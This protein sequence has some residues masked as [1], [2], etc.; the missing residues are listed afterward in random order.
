MW[1]ALA[2]AVDWDNVNNWVFGTWEQILIC[3][4]GFG[5]IQNQLS[6]T[7]C[8]ISSSDLVIRNLCF[9]RICCSFL[10]FFNLDFFF[11]FLKMILKHIWF[12]SCRMV[13]VFHFHSS[14]TEWTLLL[15]Q[16]LT[17]EINHP[18]AGAFPSDMGCDLV[19]CSKH[20]RNSD[21]GY[22]KS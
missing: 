1:M 3:A 15:N 13:H 8:K 18:G 16:N 9:G 7:L 21:S 4:S 19:G 6:Q 2:F 14:R 11:Y 12:G 20:H 17:T 5:Q 22:V 10:S